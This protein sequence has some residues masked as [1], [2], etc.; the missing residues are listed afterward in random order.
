M[1]FCCRSTDEAR[2]YFE[3]GGCDEPVAAYTAGYTNG[4]R[5]TSKTPWL[6]YIPREK[7]E[8]PAKKRLI[9][10]SWTGNRGGY[11]SSHNIRRKPLNWAKE[12]GDE[13]E[14]FEVSYTG[15]GTRMKEAL[16]TEPT[17][18][19]AEMAK[20]IGAA[21]EDGA[22]Y[23]FVGFSFGAILAYS[24]AMAISKAS[25][26]TQGPQLLVS[27]SC[28]GPSWPGRSSS[29]MTEPLHA[30]G[31]EA[32]R[33]VLERKGGTDIILKDAGM[34]K[35]YLP[36]IKADITLE[37]TYVPPSEGKAAAAFPIVAMYGTKTPARDKE[38]SAVSR[39]AAELWTAATSA[40]SRVA[41]VE[42]VDWYVLLEEAGVK[43]V[44]AEVKNGLV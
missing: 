31:E 20:E 18:L 24:V 11:G 23:A 27:V 44:L 28:E 13:F 9:F 37:E 30:L 42:G 6:S 3:S 16:R 34:S 2:A 26:G 10:F 14:L 41:A 32:F 5:P 43:A 12:L 17:A 38:G 15:R 33:S 39:Q 7:E 35:A 19:V 21:L 25:A 40:P 29:S 1:C 22:P 8:P 36:V 4:S